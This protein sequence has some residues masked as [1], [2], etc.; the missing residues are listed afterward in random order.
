MK[1]LDDRLL[2]L[3]GDALETLGSFYE[4]QLMSFSVQPGATSRL[5]ITSTCYAL[6]AM[7]AAQDPSALYGSLI[8]LD[9]ALSQLDD[10]ASTNNK[11]TP[12][13]TPVRSILC[14]MLGSDWRPDDLFQVPLLLYT[15]LQVDAR[16]DWVGTS[17]DEVTAARIRSLLEAVLQARPRRRYGLAQ[18]YSDYILFQCTKV[19]AQV[20][21]GAVT[22]P[23]DYLSMGDDHAGEDYDDDD[24]SPPREERAKEVLSVT[25]SMSGLP[26]RALPDGAPSTVALA[27]ARSIEVSY[28]TLCR[29][30][31]L[32]A[33]GAEFDVMRLSYSLLTY[34]VATGALAGTAGR[35]VVRGQGPLEGSRVSPVN[36]RLVQSALAAFFA[37]QRPDGSWDK[38]QPIYRSF[39]RT[40]RNIGNA[41]IFAVDTVASLLEHLPPEDFRP[42][43][44]GLQLLLDWIELH[45]K[46]EILPDY[47]DPETGQCYGKAIKGWSSP[48]LSPETAP[49]AW[50]T[51]Q[52]IACVSRMRTTVESL[53]HTDILEE[54]NGIKLSQKG[55]VTT[56]WDRLLD[57]DI[58]ASTGVTLKNVLEDRMIT[59]RLAGSEES[60]VLESFSAIL[61]GPPG[62]AKTTIAQ[63]L[64][65]RIGY[66]FLVIDTSEFLADGL[67]SVASRI[68]YVFQRLQALRRC[69][70]L[71]DE[72]EEFC[73]DRETPGIGMESRMLTTAMLTAINDLR[74]ANKSIFF[75]ATNRLRAFDSAITRPGRFDMQLFVGTPNLQARGIQLKQKLAD[76]AVDADT[77]QQAVEAYEAFLSSVWNEDAKY[78]N[79][80]EGVK[81]A[82]ACASIVARGSPLTE[83]QMM[84]L[85]KSQVT[86]MT[87]RGAVREEFDAS[88]G[89]SRL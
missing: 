26:S 5:S 22:P 67:T 69:V 41:F 47:C 24:E 43:L 20:Y 45:R 89:L 71:F 76:M 46:V 42:H 18:A 39:R 64:A 12:P 37:A 7:L 66:D 81:F 79:Y 54:F 13:R 17:S 80:M 2:A 77:K 15:L 25:S 31:A 72:I 14:A 4:P 49:Q 68:R 27:L 6:Q 73:L 19:Y 56:S 8:V 74:R 57:A 9:P 52:T 28:N 51:A 21:D 44:A 11:T 85:H 3:E 82:G 29:E 38:G 33:A 70:I 53:R 23:R 58:D 55:A 63:S 84:Q 16:R 78:M 62:T 75:L 50:S 65:E 36:R 34:V 86:T 30:L 83:D 87:V 59:P 48:H 40:G 32:R 88:M 35:E 1:E 61:F 60:V 10:G